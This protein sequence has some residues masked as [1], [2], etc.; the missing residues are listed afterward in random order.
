MFVCGETV[1]VSYD[2]GDFKNECQVPGSYNQLPCNCLFII[3]IS[4]IIPE[5]QLF[6]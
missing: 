4:H 2:F 6:I 1:Y 3:G 5:N